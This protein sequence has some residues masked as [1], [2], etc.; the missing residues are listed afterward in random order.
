MLCR[1]RLSPFAHESIRWSFLDRKCASNASPSVTRTYSPSSLERR[2]ATQRTRQATHRSPK[3][4]AKICIGVKALLGHRWFKAM[5]WIGALYSPSTASKKRRLVLFLPSPRTDFAVYACTH[6]RGK[7]R[8][9]D[10]NVLGVAPARR[11]QLRRTGLISSDTLSLPQLTGR[12]F[13]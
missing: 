12:H 5:W 9:H 3:S 1:L 11:W 6:L 2:N 8:P 10:A 7:S 4:A 13:V